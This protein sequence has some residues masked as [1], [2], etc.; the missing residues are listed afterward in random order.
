MK[1]CLA[2]EP[3]VVVPT[4]TKSV[5]GKIVV[6]TVAGRGCG[7]CISRS[8]VRLGIFDNLRLTSQ[9]E[10]SKTETYVIGSVRAP[11]AR[12]RDMNGKSLHFPC[13]TENERGS[14]FLPDRTIFFCFVFGGADELVDTMV[15][16]TKRHDA[17]HHH[18]PTKQVFVA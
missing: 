3:L 12:L 6:H 5:A 14:S 9:S 4:K 11:T 17:S 2:I 1:G 16:R 18:P 8:Q 7:V 15:V 10:N 13:G